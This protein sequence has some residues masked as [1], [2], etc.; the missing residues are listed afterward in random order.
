M[1]IL[2]VAAAVPPAVDGIGDYTATLARALAAR[3]TVAIA[4][5][6]LR[7]ASPVPDV[8]LFPAFDLSSPGGVRSLPRVVR[9]WKP[10]WVVLQY[11]PFSWGRRGFN[12]HLPAVIQTIRR[13]GAA[14]VAVM[15]HER[16]VP[17][18]TWPYR[19]MSLWQR[20]QYRMLARTAQ[21][22]FCSTDAWIPELRR[23]APGC[24]VHLAPAGSG[25]PRVEIERS[26]ARARL[27]IPADAFVLGFFGFAHASKPLGHVAEAYRAISESGRDVRLV[28]I[29]L[30]PEVVRA[31]LPEAAV[32]A[33]GALPADEVSRRF[34]AMD[35]LL[36]P[37]V[38]GVSTR[39]TTMM[40][41]LQHG[42][43]TLGT[44][45]EYTSPQLAR[46]DDS[47]LRLVPCGD[48][49]AFAQAARALAN[50][51]ADRL[52]IGS[53]GR[54]LFEAEYAPEMLAD[55]FLTA[56]G[57][58]RNPLGAQETSRLRSNGRDITK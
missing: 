13:S 38:D 37:F 25:I 40:T 52:R 27:D 39:R 18:T 43:A 34:S 53:A 12:P 45:G 22:L 20:P 32:V 4:T 44:V 48:A 49:R 24:G 26:T 47:A 33:D 46:E 16:Y 51:E 11:N 21:A 8:E 28:Y 30:Q 55:R 35:L 5:D 1:R 9:E 7:P 23:L 42:V 31:A 14:N 41:G 36:C 58:A 15:V 2:L 17:F 54:R 10:D 6:R 19:I 29:G 50:S 56:L 57:Q 3:A